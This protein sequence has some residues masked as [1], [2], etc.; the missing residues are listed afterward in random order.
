MPTSYNLAY[1]SKERYSYFLCVHKVGTRPFLKYFLK[2]RSN[3][4]T[5]TKAQT[6]TSYLNLYLG[7]LQ[8]GRALGR[9]RPSTR[10]NALD[11]STVFW[12]RVFLKLAT[13]CA[14]Q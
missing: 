13:L 11:L 6:N 2:N 4:W 10:N 3:S 14:D 1:M 9:G 12:L 5:E 7:Y 8:L